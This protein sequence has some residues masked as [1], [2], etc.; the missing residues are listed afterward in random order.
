[1]VERVVTVSPSCYRI[2]ESFI[3]HHFA[4]S[5]LERIGVWFRIVVMW[6]DDDEISSQSIGESVIMFGGKVYRKLWLFTTSPML[7][8][9]WRSCGSKRSK[10]HRSWLLGMSSTA[11]GSVVNLLLEMEVLLSVFEQ[12]LPHSTERIHRW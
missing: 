9:N 12:L 3:V 7:E 11:G 6:G 5:R 10:I 2:Y 1:M 4:A 8:F